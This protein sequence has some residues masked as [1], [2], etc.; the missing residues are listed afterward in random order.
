MGLSFCSFASGSSGNCYLVESENT[1]ILIDVG[2]TGKRILAGLEENGLKAEDVDAI[3]LTHEHIDHVRSI[4]MIGR[5][6]GHAEVYASGGTFAGIEEKLLPRGRWSP[7]PD[8][9]FAIGDIAVRAFSLS[10]DAI[11]PTG[12]TLRSG[13]RQV[14]VVTDTGV[15]TEEIFEQMKTADLLVL[16]ANHEVNILRMGSYPYPLQQRILGDEGHLSNETAGRILCSLLDQMHGEKVPR[17][18]LAHLSHENN[19]PQQAYLTVKNILFERDYFVDRD[20]KLAVIRRD[21]TSPLL[22]V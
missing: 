11:E 19:T 21:E 8:E 1:V 2:I 6:A 16:E 17:V 7:V 20:V 22:E 3:L 14:T 5:K 4:R 15:I 18:L 13:G 12:Y 9:E 10:H